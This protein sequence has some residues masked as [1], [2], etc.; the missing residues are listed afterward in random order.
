MV[1]AA[2]SIL[3]DGCVCFFP[4]LHT[5]GTDLTH[6]RISS[7]ATLPLSAAALF[8]KTTTK[9]ERVAK[10]SSVYSENGSKSLVSKRLFV[11]RNRAV[12]VQC[13]SNEIKCKCLAAAVQRV[14]VRLA[15][16]QHY[17]HGEG[18]VP[19]PPLKARTLRAEGR[20]PAVTEPDTAAEITPSLPV[21]RDCSTQTVPDCR[22]AEMLDRRKSEGCIHIAL[23]WAA[24]ASLK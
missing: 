8:L 9:L 12:Q 15:A 1:T 20:L 13:F 10:C 11:P 23:S 14:C 24:H 19:P 2:A 7:C 3:L 6:I 4:L 16:V 22:C 17:H 5:L 21:I 18:S